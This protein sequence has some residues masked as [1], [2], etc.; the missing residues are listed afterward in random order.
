MSVS[1]SLSYPVVYLSV[2]DPEVIDSNSDLCES[3]LSG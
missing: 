2:P 1:T 3:I